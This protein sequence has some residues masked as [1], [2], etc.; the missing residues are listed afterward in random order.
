MRF[1]NTLVVV[2]IL[3]VPGGI[4]A[5]MMSLSPSKYMQHQDMPLCTITP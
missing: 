5:L 2:S 4:L 3:I 1:A